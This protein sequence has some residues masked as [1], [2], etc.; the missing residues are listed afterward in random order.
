M[1][2][3]ETLSDGLKRELEVVV[4][5]TTLDERLDRYL[6]EMK[7]S[8]K[9]NGFR[10]GKVPLT[11]LKKMYGK[12][13]MGD[14]IGEVLNESVQQAINDR[15][16]RPATQP[17][18]DLLEGVT[19]DGV[20]EGNADLAFK[21]SYEI[22]PAIELSGFDKIEI[23]KPVAEVADEKIDEELAHLAEHNRLYDTKDG[24][25][26]E[27]D[28]VKLSFVGKIDGE[29][30]EGGAA[31][32][33]EVVIGDGRFIP[34]FEEQL[35]GVAAGTEKVIELSFPEDYPA[36]Q[37]AGKA[38]TF[39]V[40]V[41]EVT[42]PQE[43][44]IDDAFAERLGLES[45]EK[46][47]EALKSQMESA[48][49]QASREKA[50][51]A[52]LD[53]LD[54][55][56]KFEVPEKLVTAEFDAIWQQEMAERERSGRSFEDDDTTEETVRNDYQGIA[57][58]RVRLGLLLSRI[59]ENAEV[60]VNDEEL[61]RALIERVRQ[62]PGQEQQ[63]YEYFTKTPEAMASLRAPLYEDKVVDYLFELVT[64]KE[65]PV[66]ADELL[67]DP[68]GGDHDHD[69]DHEHHHHDH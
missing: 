43:T 46:L 64:L 24:P 6:S 27:G 28:K 5:A 63:A 20:V 25:A 30:F 45:L 4:P 47:R 51:R 61:Q 68:E 10:P 11:H 3:T 56:Y 21:V 53:A 55:A 39:D 32:D 65:K 62:F 41:A 26:E 29:A 1:Q 54:E 37:L 60:Q 34:G 12:R 57:D 18:V 50:K 15:D 36:E 48:Y 38:A 19:M 2:V 8:V 40:T 14:I 17:D 9:L 13:A 16:E 66:S 58:R 67:A 31:E 59:G 52:L 69:H 42:A 49:N 35:T 7:D 22:L 23:E 33:V 44:V